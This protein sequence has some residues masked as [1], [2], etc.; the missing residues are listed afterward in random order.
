MKIIFDREILTTRT[1]QLRLLNQ[2]N[3]E[4]GDKTKKNKQKSPYILTRGKKNANQHNKSKYRQQQCG[5]A[6]T[7]KK[8]DWRTKS[9]QTNKQ[10]GKQIQKQ[11]KIRDTT[12]KQLWGNDERQIL[13][14]GR[15]AFLQTGVSHTVAFLPVTHKTNTCT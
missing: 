6:H 12:T 2:R 1:R 15:V 14:K 4:N 5:E 3:T 10:T 8:S 7:E 9:K 11:N 13:P